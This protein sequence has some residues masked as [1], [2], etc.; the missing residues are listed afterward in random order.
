MPQPTG[1]L[2]NAIEGRGSLQK[3]TRVRRRLGMPCEVV[4][5]TEIVDTVGLA[6]PGLSDSRLERLQPLLTFPS[7]AL[8]SLEY[9][10]D[11]N[12]E[13]S[14]VELP[15]LI[16]IDGKTAIL[17]RLINEGLLEQC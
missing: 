9:I 12:T 4:F 6:F 14:A 1:R 16:T 10:R 5:S 13:F 3:D 2:G 7:I 8:V 17:Q 11:A 15:G